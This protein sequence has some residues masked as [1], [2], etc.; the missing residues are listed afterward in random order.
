MGPNHQILGLGERWQKEENEIEEMLW[1]RMWIQCR[2][3]IMCEE[4]R[5]LLTRGSLE[6]SAELENVT[7]TAEKARD[8]REQRQPG[9]W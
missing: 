8:K 4:W 5:T 1:K 2:G 9:P 7:G 3:M 6:L